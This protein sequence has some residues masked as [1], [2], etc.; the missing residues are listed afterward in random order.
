MVFLQKILHI[1][2][3]LNQ[4]LWVSQI[5]SATKITA[6]VITIHTVLPRLN[7][8]SCKKLSKT[9]NPQNTPQI[10]PPI[11]SKASIMHLFC[12]I[13]QYPKIHHGHFT[14]PPDLTLKCPSQVV[15]VRGALSVCHP[16]LPCRTRIYAKYVT[17][18]LFATPFC[19]VCSSFAYLMIFDV[20]SKDVPDIHVG[21][22]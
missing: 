22:I 5:Y 9:P 4:L 14:W 19:P 7:Q 16:F 3:R 1:K 13:C 18:L 10:K 6:N 12:F 20:F 8:S 2:P 15:R 21:N 17:F 11:K